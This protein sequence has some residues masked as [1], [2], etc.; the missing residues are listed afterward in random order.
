MAE[1]LPLKVTVLPFALKV[2]LCV[3]VPLL[4][5][6]PLIFISES[7]LSTQISAAQGEGSITASFTESILKSVTVRVL[8]PELETS[9]NA[10][11]TPEAPEGLTNQAKSFVPDPSPGL[12]L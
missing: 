8:Y 10:I 11:F 4:F 5:K 7:N 6:E 3:V 12:V 2:P 1:L 9:V